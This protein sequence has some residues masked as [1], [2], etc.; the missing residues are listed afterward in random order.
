MI[1]RDKLTSFLNEILPPVPGI[2]DP[3]NN[4]LQV[5]GKSEVGKVIFGVDACLAL[6]KKAAEVEADFIFVHHGLSWGDGWQRLT[7]QEATRLKV[8]F[9][10]DISLYA[11]HLPLDADIRVGHNFEIARRLGLENL[12]SAFAYHGG[13]I[14]CLGH[15]PETIDIRELC[16]KANHELTTETAAY[17]FGRRKIRSLGIVSGGGGDAIE[18]CARRGTDC[19]LTGEITHKHYHIMAEAEQTVLTAGHYQSEIPG[20][21]AVARTVSEQY[22]IE[23]EFIDLPTGL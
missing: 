19:L 18:E 8:L 21:Q 5:E 4:G 11:S 1:T 10:S 15:F 7:G 17:P 16:S 22:N 23:T 13:T 20:L 3:S 14:G 12:E 6:F 9:K 2:E